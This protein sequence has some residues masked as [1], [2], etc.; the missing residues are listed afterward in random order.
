[1]PIRTVIT[2][3][4]VARQREVTSNFP[5]LGLPVTGYEIHQGRSRRV[6]LPTGEVDS[7]QALFDDSYLGMVDNSLSVWGTY[8]HGIFDNGPWRRAWLNRL[9]QQRGLKSLPTGVANYR[10]Q[11]EAMLDSLAAT[12]KTHLDL[13]PILSS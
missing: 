9:R 11:R 12:V 4:K 10:E 1:L 6:E 8:L 7:Y 2:G 5:Q 13:T 3:Q